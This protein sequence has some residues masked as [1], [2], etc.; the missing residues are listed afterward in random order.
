MRSLVEHKREFGLRVFGMNQEGGAAVHVAAQ[1][2]Q[3]FVG[4]IPRLH[5]NIIQFIAEKVFYNPLEARLDLQKIG[6]HPDRSEAALHD[7]RL[8]KT[9]DGLGGISVLGNHRFQRSLL[10]E[11]CGEF[12]AQTDRDGSWTSS[13][14]GAWIR[15]AGEAG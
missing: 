10:A 15:S 2:A 12:G 9:A 4:R 7:S 6:E 14:P 11:R 1:Q 8:E 13:L 3:A 5:D